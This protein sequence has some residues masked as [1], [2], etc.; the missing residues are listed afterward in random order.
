MLVANSDLS[1][2]G[3]EPAYGIGVIGAFAPEPEGVL[4]SF[5]PNIG[6]PVYSLR[7]SSSTNVTRSISLSAERP[8]PIA[9]LHM[10]DVSRYGPIP[11]PYTPVTEPRHRVGHSTVYFCP[12]WPWKRSIVA[13][14]RDP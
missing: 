8:A 7:G 5:L 3:F 1:G 9:A 10:L 13:L 6:H 14:C 4:I 12:I 2:A 11:H